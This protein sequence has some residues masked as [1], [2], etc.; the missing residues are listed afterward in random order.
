MSLKIEPEEISFN[1]LPDYFSVK[2]R[3]TSISL[4]TKTTLDS[5]QRKVIEGII[6]DFDGVLISFEARFGWPLLRALQKT[7][8][9]LQRRDI[10]R[11]MMK[12]YG[13]MTEI[14][15]L[16]GPKLVKFFFQLAKKFGM[17]NIQSVKFLLL[18]VILMMKNKA[19]ITAK[20]GVRE[21]LRTILSQGYKVAL[22]TNSSRKTINLA[23]K[24]IPELNKFDMILTRDDVQ[25]MK[26]AEEGFLQVLET[27]DLQP[28]RVLSIGD[29]ASDIIA[30]RKAGVTTVALAGDPIEIMKQH[31]EE[32]NPDFL[33][34]D[35]QIL[36]WLLTFLQTN[37]AQMEETID[38][39]RAHNSQDEPLLTY[40]RFLPPLG[41]QK[42]VSSG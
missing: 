11:V 7:I 13:K 32:Y 42:I 23:L 24:K 2:N 37:S 21:V 16:K 39:A 8:P 12:T 4:A 36:P 40:S 18:L 15:N 20:K 26:P 30:G 33:I 35:L 27:L 34:Q 10:E 5:P 17:N 1:K 3:M 9:S 6:L 22:F 25:R 19:A 38:F 29:Q 31:L 41:N 14:E 28:E